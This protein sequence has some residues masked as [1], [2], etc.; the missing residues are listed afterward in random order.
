[1]HFIETFVALCGI[2]LL[3]VGYRRKQR[4][5]MALAGM[6]LLVAGTIGRVADKAHGP[7]AVAQAPVTS[8]SVP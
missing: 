5:M 8:A 6:M 3:V 2:A 4:R 7:A 1:M